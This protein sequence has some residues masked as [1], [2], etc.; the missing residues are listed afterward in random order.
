MV[1]LMNRFM[2]SATVIFLSISPITAYAQCNS[3]EQ[4]L[5][6]SYTQCFITTMSG[7]NCPQLQTLYNRMNQ[8]LSQT[9]KAAI[10]QSQR[11]PTW[12][13]YPPSGST[14]P[15]GV[16][17]HGGGVYSVPGGAVCGPS[18]CIPLD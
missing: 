1:M 8:E 16:Y 2:L 12:D 18:G 15:G 11:Q 3:K 17:D 6:L 7:G 13:S 4:Q 10:A 14:A 9:C 5:I